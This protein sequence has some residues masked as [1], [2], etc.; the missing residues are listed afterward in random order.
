MTGRTAPCSAERVVPHAG[1]VFLRRCRNRLVPDT[2]IGGTD[3]HGAA[4]ALRATDEESSRPSETGD[5]PVTDH[6]P[7][8]MRTVA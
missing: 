7:E 3:V 1:F 5:P 8:P 4:I 6:N 2:V